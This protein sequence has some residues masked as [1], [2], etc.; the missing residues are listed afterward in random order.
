MKVF[1]TGA[2]GFVGGELLAQ[3]VAEGIAVRCL[4][5]PGSESGLPTMAGV[6]IHM[7]DA[8]RP[9]S[10]LGGLSGCQA[11]IN[12]IGIIREFPGKGISFQKMHV[13]AT[14]NL[15]AAAQ[16]QGVKRFLQM[17]ANGTRADAVTAYHKTKWQAEEI[18]RNADLD[19]TIFRPSL[20]YGPHDQFVTMLA[21][22]LRKLPVMPVLGNGRYRM[23]PVSVA[24]VACSYVRALSRP[25][26]IGQ[27]F[28]CCGPQPHS[29]DEI[30]NMIGAALGKARVRKLH[31]PLVLMRPVIRL[32]E[33]LPLFPITSAQLQMLLEENCCDPGPWR[34]FF[35]I[36]AQSFAAGIAAY[37]KNKP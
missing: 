5:R 3:L 25:D 24:Q 8:T 17:S 20:I 18:V 22:M 26:S 27:V 28:H 7:G 29:Y 37:L 4:V 14:G 19:W 33:G 15:V 21:E 23:Q 35:G 2:T 11:V 31:H 6:E 13:E 36:E 30:L 9:E 10:L 12:L 32:L 34:S 16:Q 1:L